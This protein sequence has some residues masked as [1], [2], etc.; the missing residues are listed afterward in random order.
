MKIKRETGTDMVRRWWGVI[1]VVLTVSCVTPVR[2]EQLYLCTPRD[3]GTE[4]QGVDK[5]GILVREIP[6]E[7]GDTLSGI[8]RRFSGHGSYY[9]Q[10][11]LFNDVK[12]PDRI[13][14][15]SSLKVPVGRG[16]AE[17]T[18]ES[19]TSRSSGKKG[20]RHADNRVSSAPHAALGALL[21]SQHKE[22]PVADKH[23]SA[24]NKGIPTG[25][26]APPPKRSSSS[27]QGVESGQML[28][29]RALAAFRKDDFSTALELFNRYLAAD[30][31]SPQAADAS[32]YKGEC[33]L[34]LSR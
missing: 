17:E 33:Y 19:T 13:Y 25:Q 28:Y 22:K 3:A 29:N 2:G 8:S 34:K 30:P 16:T 23:Y 10:I 27:R 26:A 1:L 4:E 9:P 6:V 14:A 24:D 21:P 11:L 31:T 7:K 5:G 32:L 12:N 15:G 20:K 18:P